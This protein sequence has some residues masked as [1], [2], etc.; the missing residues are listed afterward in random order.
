[1]SNKAEQPAVTV[2]GQRCRIVE[3]PSETWHRLGWVIEV[4]GGCGYMCNDGVVRGKSTGVWPTH[5]SA[6]AFIAANRDQP[7]PAPP[8]ETR[9]ASDLTALQA[10]NDR[11]KGELD[12]AK[13]DYEKQRPIQNT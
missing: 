9:T 7:A 2:K 4:E 8:A 1:M 5:A 6:E 10:E 3:A 11:L 12:E 13:S